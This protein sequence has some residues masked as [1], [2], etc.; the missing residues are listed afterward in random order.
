[1]HCPSLG[2]S[3]ELLHPS[4]PWRKAPEVSTQAYVQ[5]TQQQSTVSVCLCNPC[6][7][8]QDMA[9]ASCKCARNIKDKKGSS[10]LLW[11]DVRL[12]FAAVNPT[13]IPNVIYILCWSVLP[14]MLHVLALKCYKKETMEETWNKKS[15]W[16]LKN[17]LL[18]DGR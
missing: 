5:Q 17:L 2:D 9:K 18:T 1:M 3:K 10:T 11:F 12:L 14:L 7:Q 4:I 16:M 15:C 6:P 13:G 8:E